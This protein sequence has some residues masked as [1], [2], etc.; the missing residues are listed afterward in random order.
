MIKRRPIL[1][2]T[3]AF[4]VLI[5]AVTIAART[6]AGKSFG[7][8]SAAHELPLLLQVHHSVYGVILFL[9][10]LLVKNEAVRK[11]LIIIGLA[12]L[13]S[14]L[15]HHLVYLPLVYGNIGWHWP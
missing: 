1:V 11:W 4:S 3:A 5:E 6:I 9:C 8:F 2:W 7:E 13:F 14:D 10:G 12:L 15:L